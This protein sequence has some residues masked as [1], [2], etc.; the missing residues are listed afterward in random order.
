MKK[1]I[2]TAICVVACMIMIAFPSHASEK[3]ARM[4]SSQA[5]VRS[6]ETRLLTDTWAICLKPGEEPG[7]VAKSVGAENLGQIG[8]LPGICLFRFPDTQLHK[9]AA[10][11][12]RKLRKE[13]G[14]EWHVQ[15]IARWRFPRKSRSSGKSDIGHQA[16][17]MNFDDPLFSEQWH[18]KNTGQSG[19]TSGEDINVSPVWEH[20]ISGNGIVIGIADDGLQYDHP[21]IAANYRKELSYDFNDDDSDPA[22]SKYD[23]HGT[24]AGGAAAAR[25]NNTCGLGVAY[26]AGLAG[27][28]LIAV[29]STDA[30]E[31]D[32]L[33]FHR[34]DIHIYSN[35]WGPDDDA[36]RLEEP[37]P[38]TS[39]ALADNIQN[40][41]NG[42]G[43]IYVW[44]AGN[45]KSVDD[46]INYDGYANSRFTIAVG[47]VDHKGKQPYYAEPGAAMIVVAPSDGNGAGITTSDLSGRQGSSSDDCTDDFGGTSASAP[48]AAGIIALML[49]TNPNLTWRDVQHILIR[50]AVRNDPQDA[51]WAVNGAGLHISHKYGFGRADA[52]GAVLLSQNWQQVGEAILLSPDPKILNLPIPDGDEEGISSFIHVD[53]NI[54][55]EHVEIVLNARHEY[56]GDLEVILISPS[57]TK[58]ILAESHRDRNPDYKAWKFMTVRNWNESSSGIWQLDIADPK[59]GNKGTFVFWELILH[60]T[61]DAETG[62]QPPLAQRDSVSADKDAPVS[63]AVLN[64]DTDPD[65]DTLRVTGVSAPGYGTAEVNA[66]NNT[67][68]YTPAPGFVGEDSFPYT[69]TDDTESVSGIIS[70]L[71]GEE[72]HV[73]EGENLPA[74]IPSGDSEGVIQSISPDIHG[75]VRDINVVL[76]IQHSFLA[77]LRAFL[78]SPA[79]TRLTLFEELNATKGHLE[80]TILD[81]EAEENI[82]D[83]NSPFAGAYRP[84]N[85]LDSLDRESVAGEWQLQISDIYGGSEGTLNAWGLEV[86]HLPFLENYP[87]LARDDTEVTYRNQSLLAEVLEND[88]DANTDM[89]AI[90]IFSDPE[91]GTALVNGDKTVTY[92]PEKDFTGTDTFIYMVSDGKSGNSMATV[93]IEVLSQPAGIPSF[94]LADAILCLRLLAGM[95]TEVSLSFTDI[96]EDGNIGLAEAI[97]ILQKLGSH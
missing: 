3:H 26:R 60:G 53:Q 57:G 17:R 82:E 12:R 24:S 41:R 37:G 30:Q 46:N 23:A 76:N 90:I 31:A 27:L 39:A 87:P 94:R 77:S 81:D 48:L 2:Y 91:H 89:L 20:E 63:I 4:P 33:S 16:S 67:V 25:D 55:L 69:V 29:E 8:Y 74:A 70:V 61:K 72:C 86:C 59:A 7:A 95:D 88:S 43:N 49:E 64:N 21:D 1:N 34:D 52:E 15:Q 9:K 80:D 10:D 32:A 68:T 45:G 65:G 75:I 35:S 19:G 5:S 18:L 71:T 56:R 79:G 92:T 96:D 62:N 50:S 85:S 44:A 22:P 42:L 93:S 28:R 97:H 58:N 51:G 11:V 73:F 6:S 78:I 84:I 54:S 66:D 13:G 38:L 40:G 36:K 47:A 83:G 14:I